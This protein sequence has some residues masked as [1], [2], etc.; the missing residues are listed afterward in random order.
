MKK[1]LLLSIY[2]F[3]VCCGFASIANAETLEEIYQQA[4]ENDHRFKAARAA[5]EAGKE[6][7]NLGRAGLLPSLNGS[8]SWQANE[9]VVDDVTVRDGDSTG[10]ALSLEQTLFSMSTWHSFK[11]SEASAM[12]AEAQF[13]FAE[14][15]LIIR[16]AEAYFNA[17]KAIDDLDTALAEENALEHQLEQTRQRFQVGL[18]AITEVHE[19]QAAYDSSTV[20]RLSAEGQLGIAFEALEVITGQPNNQLSP[21]KT[22]FPVVNPT[23]ADREKWVEFALENN[24][25]LATASLQAKASRS[26]AKAARA[27]HYPTVTASASWSNGTATDNLGNPTSIPPIPAGSDSD[28]EDTMFSVNLRVPLFNGGAVS[29]SRRQANAAA[30]QSRE[31]YLQTQR[32]VIQ[33]TRSLH[34]SVITGAASVKARA[35]AIVSSQSALD[36]TQAGYEVGTRDLVD[37]LNAQRNLYLAQ[38]NY[39]T[40]LYAYVMF[41]LQL[42]EA[43]GMLEPKDIQELSNWLDKNKTVNRF[44]D[45]SQAPN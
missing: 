11:S 28:F 30:E 31:I 9:Q 3:V 26:D 39:Y 24:Y 15:D 25:S 18:T 37:V 29:A 34:L 43:A 7:V 10:Y 2:T 22:D 33:Q 42:K 19:A 6:S 23:P 40:A 5:Y 1:P 45:R 27:G 8:V 35:Q 38:R 17:L 20:S 44:S 16:T 32:D 14:Q 13:K 21:L 12:A 4:L 41:T 36:A